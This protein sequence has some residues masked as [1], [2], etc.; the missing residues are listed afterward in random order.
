MPDFRAAE[1]CVQLLAQVAGRAG[2]GEQPGRV[3]V[4]AM[5]PDEP[6]VQFAL[7]HDVVAFADAE[8]LRRRALRFPPYARLVALRLAGNVETRVQAAAERLAEAAGRLIAR[9]EPADVL[10][11]ASAPLA[12]L[13]GKHRWQLLLRAA[14]HPPL[15]RLARQL[16]ESHRR[17]GLAG[18]DLA[19]DVDPVSLL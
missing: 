13:R 16:V 15:H 8:L 6:A 9:G 7:R 1:R 18:V 4:Q 10:G 5:K 2:R 11:P 3:L 14:D 17:S 12:R 19:V